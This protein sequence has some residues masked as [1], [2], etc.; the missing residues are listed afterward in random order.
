MDPS[1]IVPHTIIMGGL[2]LLQTTLFKHGILAGVTPDFSL[3][4]LL[5]SANQHGRLKG[6]T[7]GFISGL[8]QDFLSVAPMGLHALTRTVIGYLYGVFRGKLF[9]DPFLMPLLMAAIG[10]LLKALLQFPL[11]AL[12]SPEHAPMVFTSRLA[13]ELGMNTLIS[14]LLYALLKGIRVIRVTR[15]QP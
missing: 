2:V 8:V 6:E 9:V 1:G 12:F 7:S 13:I 4:V 3:L 5:F 10:T 11:L 14:P 15:Q